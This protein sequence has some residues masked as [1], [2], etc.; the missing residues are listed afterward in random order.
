[1]S[2]TVVIIL[3]VLPLALA[4]GGFAG[5]A[6]GS[7]AGDW[8]ET[9]GITDATTWGGRVGGLLGAVSILAYVIRKTT[10]DERALMKTQTKR[11]ETP[12]S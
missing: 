10:Q 12:T 1:M 3:I 7:V 6:A 9:L 8:L 11:R 4:I 2:R 5:W